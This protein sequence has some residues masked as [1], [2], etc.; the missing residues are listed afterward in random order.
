VEGEGCADALDAAGLLA[1]TWRGGCAAVTKAIPQLVAA[2]AGREVVLLP[3]A[4]APGGQAMR[5]IVDAKIVLRDKIAALEL[6][7]RCHG[8]LTNKVE[9]SGTVEQQVKQM[10][11]Y[12]HAAAPADP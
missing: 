10:V 12:L 8:M 1:I 3:D 7:A 4:D 2:L 6:L 11:V 5:E 9:H